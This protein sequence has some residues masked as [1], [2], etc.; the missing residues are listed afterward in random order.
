MRIVFD[1]DDTSVI[2]MVI[3]FEWPSVWAFRIGWGYDD[4]VPIRPWPKWHR[5]QTEK[6]YQDFC[7]GL[8]G[9][10]VGFSWG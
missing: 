10:Y 4:E 2:Q 8:M 7:I 3:I 6:G 5:K 9:F 1:S